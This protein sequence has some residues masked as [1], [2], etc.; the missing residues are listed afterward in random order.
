MSDIEALL[1]VD[2]GLI[3]PGT[4]AFFVEDTDARSRYAY[5]IMA[6]S[7]IVAAIAAGG[8]GAGRFLVMLMVLAAAGLAVLAWPP[9][10]DAAAQP[11]KRQVIVMTALGV[12]LRDEEGLRSWRFEDL[13]DVIYEMS[14][15]RPYLILL[16]RTGARHSIDI[17]R[18][19]H[20]RRVAEALGSRV[21]LHRGRA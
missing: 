5:A 15:N 12:I 6:V 20:R 16:E 19:G 13:A 18:F 4:V 21:Q 11:A 17:T 2:R 14:N 10:R 9:A 8:V 3:P 7:T 1:S